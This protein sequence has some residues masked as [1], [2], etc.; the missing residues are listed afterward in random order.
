MITNEIHDAVINS[1]VTQIAQVISR[2]AAPAF[3]LALSRH[4]FLLLFHA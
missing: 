4:F 3:L 2:V 1:P